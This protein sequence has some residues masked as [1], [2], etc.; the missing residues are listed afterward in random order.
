[1]VLM[2]TQRK[3]AQVVHSCLQIQH[4]NAVMLMRP[5]DMLHKTRYKFSDLCAAVTHLRTS[6]RVMC[7]Q[8]QDPFWQ[9]L[10]LP[11]HCTLILPDRLSN[12]DWLCKTWQCEY[13]PCSTNMAICTFKTC[14]MRGKHACSTGMHRWAAGQIRANCSHNLVTLGTG[15]SKSHSAFKNT[16]Q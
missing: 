15:R 10:A 6:S 12:S 11:I 8:D 5:I 7:E 4:K 14:L 16:V 1:M 9:G 3:A 13:D 2:S